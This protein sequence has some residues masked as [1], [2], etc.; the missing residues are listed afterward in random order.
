MLSYVKNKQRKTTKLLFSAIAVGVLI[1]GWYNI[2]PVF[3]Q[4]KTSSIDQIGLSASLFN[5]ENKIITNG[6]YE[7]RFA[8]YSK[9]RSESDPYPSNT[10]SG[11]RLWEETQTV[12]VK[13]G[14]FRI[15]LGAVN[16]LPADMTFESGDYYV[17]MRIG[18]DSEIVPRKKL[19]S[20]PSAINAKYLRGRTFGTK[21]GDILLL[22]KG[23]KV[24]IK[25]LP[26]GSGS[27]QLLL[28]DDT[29]LQDV[30]E[31]N[32]DVGTTSETFVFG[33]GKSIASTNFSLH[34]SS[35]SSTPALR[36]NATTQTWQFSNDGS[37]FLDIS[38]SSGAYLPLTGGTMTG[39][40]VFAAGQTFGGATLTELGYLS[41]ASSNIQTQLTGKA[42]VSHAHDAADITSGTLAVSRGGTGAGTFTTNGLLYGNGTSAL[43]VTAAGTDAQILVANGT[44]V[45]TFVTLSSD[46]TITNAG[47]LTI[48]A[49][50]VALT[51][52]T[53]GNYVATI[54]NGNGISGSS[55]T[56]GGTPTLAIDL[57]DSADGT[58]STSS[59]SG[60]EFAGGSSNELT[61][62]QGCA[63]GQGI[64]WND[65]T[66]V[67]ECGSFSSGISGSGTSGHV[68]YWS[69]S[70]S[71][72]SEAQLATSRGGTGLDGS[73]ASNGT[74]LIG[75]GS[76]YT[77]AT[78]TAGSGALSITNGSGSI[79]L[80]VD[81][82]TSGTTATTSSNSG[83]EI[84]SDG[85]RLLGGCSND[86]VLAW[87]SASSIWTCS[88]K[89]GGTSDWTSTGS[90]TYLTDTS[91]DV[92]LG[93]STSSNA[94]FYFDVVTGNRMIFEG[95]GADDA[96]ETILVIANPTS[97]Q[98]ITIPDITGAL[99]TTGDTGTVTGLMI[100]NDTV[101]LG[102]DTSGNY[103]ATITNGNGISGSSATEGGTPTL[104]IDLLD[105]VDGTG[106]TS[107]NS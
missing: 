69:G 7:V 90:V 43:Q 63:N 44:G 45:P 98:T 93:G 30:H 76:G 9:D 1:L 32:T 53:T 41:G 80:N 36:F 65:T 15:F 107:S 86:Q 78:L 25:N 85:I 102:T 77:L 84:A 105:S 51:T 40:I 31:Q 94:K 103:V 24:N 12:T 89:T 13:N 49:N 52:D 67:W 75:N 20:V 34:V 17:G 101:A 99:V 4:V 23:G 16:S 21:E 3:S 47:V 56:E 92:A 50:A 8:I 55:T 87:N 38:G 70:S 64:S 57:L 10:D 33:S 62:L 27:N 46:A 74:L 18:T 104:A 29:R 66:N 59:N 6:T 54:T 73:A 37:S 96:N 106:S 39:S 79:T 2:R 5:S 58:G 61:L 60:L 68:T 22:G 28:G 19:G 95:T 83:L 48:A 97:D 42:N 72:A 14:M 11:S 71:L 91:D 100:L 26:T 88:N 82:T 35:T 81:A